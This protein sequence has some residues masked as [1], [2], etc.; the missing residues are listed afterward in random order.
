MKSA[1]DVPI[2]KAVGKLYMT[3]CYL[4]RNSGKLKSAIEQAP[5]ALNV[6]GC[7]LLTIHGMRFAGHR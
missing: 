6:T 1:L 4:L 3:N 7:V 5:E 2:L